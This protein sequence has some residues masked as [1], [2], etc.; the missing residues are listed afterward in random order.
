MN[1]RPFWATSEWCHCLLSI[2]QN[3]PEWDFIIKF[4]YLFCM[5]VHKPLWVCGGQ[6]NNYRTPLWV[7][8]IKFRS[9]CLGADVFTHW[10]ILTA[11]KWFLYQVSNLFIWGSWGGELLKWVSHVSQADVLELT[12][13]PRLT[14]KSHSKLPALPPKCGGL[15]HKPP[16]PVII[17]IRRIINVMAAVK[18]KGR[19]RRMRAGE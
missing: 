15:S 3:Y 13:Q 9:S 7:S 16:D 2:F 6:E 5:C 4:I 1:S 14:P 11:S 17:S 10:A 19:G 8:G 18:V 12:M